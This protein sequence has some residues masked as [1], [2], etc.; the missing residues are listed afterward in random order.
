MERSVVQ[1][2]AC[3]VNTY[4][5]IVPEDVSLLECVVWTGGSGGEGRAGEGR[6]GKERRGEGRGG[7]GRGG[8]G[9]G[10]CVIC[11]DRQI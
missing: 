2:T 3:L 1:T 4:Q 8:E 11:W 5:L 6:G 10:R 7:E 9:R